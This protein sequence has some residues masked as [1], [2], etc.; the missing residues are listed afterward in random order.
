MNLEF[1]MIRQLVIVKVTLP[2]C[3]IPPV[4]NY[5]YL[6]YILLQSSGMCNAA[7]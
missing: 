5:S 6:A 2:L 4:L 1:I 7:E 3:I